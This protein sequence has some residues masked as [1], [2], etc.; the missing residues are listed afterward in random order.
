MKITVIVAEYNPLH[1][2]HIYHIEQAK[3]FGDPII[4]LMSGSFVQ[5]GEPAI[6]D[7]YKRAEASVLN[8][9]DAV[10]EVPAP[11]SFAPADKYTLGAFKLINSIN[12]DIRLSFGSESGDIDTIIQ[13]AKI[14][15][16]EPNEY[17]NLIKNNLDNGLS[18]AKARGN[19]LEEYAKN[20]NIQIVDITKPNNIL[21]V[22]Y[23][24]NN[25]LSDKKCELVTH[26]RIG[27]YKGNAESGYQSASV[28][29]DRIIKGETDL[30][31]PT[32]TKR[33][34]ETTPYVFNGSVYNFAIV[35]ET[36]R[37]ISKIFDVNEGLE[38]RLY[39]CVKNT[40]NFADALN[41]CVCGRYSE[42]RIH[43]VM[44][45]ILL[46]VSKEDFLIATEE[47]PLFNLLSAKKSSTG[48]FTYI[49]SKI[50]TS[51]SALEKGESVQARLTAKA[52]NYYKIIKE[53][54]FD[55]TI[56]VD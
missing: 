27:E 44:T 21:A 56:F 33:L 14:I 54:A 37:T 35:R 13:T 1:R 22:E 31:V 30:D 47:P 17:K 38:N 11:F 6:F 12:A 40:N 18:L 9:V 32:E 39:E 52:Q 8:G 41:S 48:L 4:V 19:A 5:R 16:D 20:N 7:K 34:I 26:K 42:S 2:G 3:K 25:I 55:H 45:N 50:I 10:F 51:Q 46:G 49:D 15:F 29:R 36:P 53:H 24:K 28:I 43:R 23:A